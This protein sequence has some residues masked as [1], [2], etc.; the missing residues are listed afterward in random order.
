ELVYTDKR[1][2]TG[3]WRNRLW[4]HSGRASSDGDGAGTTSGKKYQARRNRRPETVDCRDLAA[5]RTNP[6]Q[7]RG[8]HDSRREYMR[9]CQTECLGANWNELRVEHVRLRRIPL[10]IADGVVSKYRIFA[11]DDIVHAGHHKVFINLLHRTV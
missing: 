7:N 6:P 1:I 4:A 3:C 5:V 9:L 10:P 11:G 2:V 8:I